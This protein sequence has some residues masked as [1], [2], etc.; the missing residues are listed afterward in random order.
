[1]INAQDMTLP[2]REQCELLNV[3]RSAWYYTAS[4]ESD[5]NVKLMN[6]IDELHLD[7][8][9]CGSRMLRDYLR[10]EGYIVNRK[11]IQRLMGIMQ[12]NAIYPKRNLSKRDLENRIYPYL[13]RRLNIDHANQVWSTDITYIRMD[14]GWVYLAA[15]ID[16]HTRAV[17]SWRISNTCDRFFCIEAL[18]EAIA[19]YGKPEIFNTDQGSTFTAPDF[20]KVLQVNEINISMDGKGRALDNIF[21]ERF[22]RTL[23]QEEVYLKSYEGMMAAEK[24]IGTYIEHYNTKRPHSSLKGKC[25]ILVYKD[26]VA[27]AA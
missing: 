4:R 22:W 18:E 23:K 11:R 26:L 9:T 19:K 6:R 12:I 1:M 15:V 2:I 7:H 21:I 24:S 20:L 17:L 10:L 27:Q 14:K 25:P 16:W 3:S 5:E 13:L 8:P